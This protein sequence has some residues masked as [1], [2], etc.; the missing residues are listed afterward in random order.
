MTTSGRAVVPL[1]RPHRVAARARDVVPIACTRFCEQPG[2]RTVGGTKDPDVAAIVA[3]APD[4][5]VV[6]DEE[7]RRE[8]FDALDGGRPRAPSMSPCAR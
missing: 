3:L 8:D 5:V 7:N 4:L 2:S 1:V 6:N